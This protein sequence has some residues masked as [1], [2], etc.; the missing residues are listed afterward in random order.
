[1]NHRAAHDSDPAERLE[2]LRDLIR[3]GAYEVDPEA[4][5]L[6]MLANPTWRDQLTR[7]AR[8]E[9]DAGGQCS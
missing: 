3:S 1:V 2:Q 6:A 7:W 8:L 9:G 4:V 5:A